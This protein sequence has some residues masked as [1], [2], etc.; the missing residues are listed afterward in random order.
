MIAAAM[1][2]SAQDSGGERS[3]PAG[4]TLRPAPALPTQANQAFFVFGFALQPLGMVLLRASAVA[5]EGEGEDGREEIEG[6]A[7][8]AS[9]WL[10]RAC[11]T[12]V[13]ACAY[14]RGVEQSNEQQREREGRQRRERHT[15]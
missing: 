11:A 4:G 10:V 3:R 1:P 8:E 2:V 13:N 15:P 7:G 9:L 6:G 5:G 12:C 14:V